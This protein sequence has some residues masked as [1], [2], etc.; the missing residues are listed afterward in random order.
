MSL[1][2][3]VDQ[4]KIKQLEIVLKG[5]VQGSIE[6]IKDTLGRIPS[7]EVEVKII[8]SAAGNINESDILLAKASNAIVI[9]FNVDVESAA[10]AEADREGIEI[11]LYQI[12]FELLED[13]KAAMEGLLE[14]DVVETVTGRALVRQVFNLSSGIVAGS[15]IEYGKMTRG[16][17]CK[18]LRG[19]EQ[20]FK[21]RIGGLKRFKDDVKEVEK[22]YECGIL[23]DGFK[24]IKEGDIVECFRKDTIIRRLEKTAN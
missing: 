14:P 10:R 21:G 23:L 7:D 5:D 15:F 1:K 18:V 13:L 6:A 3:E 19:T 4:H 22:G 2:S 12:I 17:E 11:R 16:S 8:H 24:A 9:G 20:V